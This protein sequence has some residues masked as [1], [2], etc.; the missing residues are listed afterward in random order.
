[1]LG[2]C[3]VVIF[4]AVLLAGCASLSK[5]ECEVGDW[6]SLGKSDGYSG[7]SSFSR[8]ASHGEACSK[9]GIAVDQIQYQ[10]GHS[11]GLLSYC[12]FPRAVS[13]G[14]AGR[15][16]A[17]VCEGERDAEFRRGH[18]AGMELYEVNSRIQ[19]L[20]QDISSAERKQKKVEAGSADYYKLEAEIRANY[21]EINLLSVQKGQ[22]Q[23]NLDTLLASYN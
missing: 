18:S 17:G 4:S 5:S 21:R 9:Y 16:Y 3:S 11:E 8:L 7:Y 20:Q 23:G 15:Q 1:M 12:T 19:S 14:R 6:Y 2:R 22:I 10:R 13:E